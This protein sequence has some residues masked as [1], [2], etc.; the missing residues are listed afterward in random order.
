MKLSNG[1]HVIL[2]KGTV[3]FFA[4]DNRTSKYR[5]TEKTTVE[6]VDGKVS[7]RPVTK[8]DKLTFA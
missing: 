1:L 8:F 7:V 5:T 2:P 6:L 3:L 4:G